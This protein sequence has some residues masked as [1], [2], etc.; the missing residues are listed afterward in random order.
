M[1]KKIN[2][3]PW[4]IG[5]K[6]KVKQLNSWAQ[7]TDSE[8]S[9][10]LDNIIPGDIIIITN[11]DPKR[12]NGI[13]EYYPFQGTKEGDSTIY[14]FCWNGIDGNEYQLVESKITFEEGKWYQSENW[15]TNQDYIKCKSFNSEYGEIII[16]GTVID[17]GYYTDTVKSWTGDIKSYREVPL[18]EIQE[19]L[20][21]EHVD[22][23][24]KLDTTSAKYL[25][26]SKLEHGKV[27]T[28]SQGD[29]KYRTIWRFNKID[30][31]TRTSTWF[32]TLGKMNPVKEQ[33]ESI[34]GFSNS[35]YEKNIEPASSEQIKWL[36]ACE[37][38]GKFIPKEDVISSK[39]DFQVGKWYKWFPESIGKWYL[40][41][42]KIE[43]N[44]VYFGEIIDII[45]KVHQIASGESSYCKDDSNW[46]EEV[47][48][49]EVKKY[50]PSTSAKEWWYSLKK[51]DYVVC[52]GRSDAS[53]INNYIYKVSKID[54]TPDDRGV[55]FSTELD[56]RGSTTNGWHTIHFRLATHEESKKYDLAKKP[57]CIDEEIES[58]KEGDCIVVTKD[59]SGYN[60]QKDHIYK[61]I[62]D[63]NKYPDGK[64]C[65]YPYLFYQKNSSIS[66]EVIEVRKATKEE[67][68]LWESSPDLEVPLDYMP[69][70][71]KA[72]DYIRYKGTKWDGK[73]NMYFGN[74]GSLKGDV[75]I[76]DEI[77]SADKRFF[78]KDDG[79]VVKNGSL[80]INDVEIITKE[81]YLEQIHRQ[82]ARMEKSKR[83][84]EKPKLSESLMSAKVELIDFSGKGAGLPSADFFFGAEKVNPI[85]IPIELE[86]VKPIINN[87][88][89]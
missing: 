27:Y 3:F 26:V 5:D 7:G 72:G 22:K 56:S 77:S 18:E 47:T 6:L 40:K 71:V 13:E 4:K 12:D 9:A 10:P 51:D 82:I 78:T 65:N 20:P 64:Y 62:C 14:G 74:Y 29:E 83:G 34:S 53:Y 54:D 75:A 43:E 55:R 41:V 60:G 76:A 23:I 80:T 21:D 1:M 42:N 81:E 59:V 85:E 8:A 16:K 68:E 28:N 2:D 48:F 36:E 79:R 84:V 57:V 52:T 24:V 38:A 67:A 32:K 15:C 44:N 61:L 37:K 73:W 70:E 87:N 31:E 50:L 46:G 11:I 89:K 33:Y 86:K 69:Q 49:E 25:K 66:L 19:Y 30:K 58:Y 88:L 17:K 63:Q 35:A 39:I 45:T